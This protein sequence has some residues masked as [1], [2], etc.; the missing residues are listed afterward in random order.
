MKLRAGEHGAVSLR[1]GERLQVSDLVGG[2]CCQLVAVNTG[3]PRERFSAPNTMLLNKQVYYAEGATL[4]SYLCNPMLTIVETSTGH[5]AL[6]GPSSEGG[7]PPDD[8][9]VEACK[10]IGLARHQVPYPFLVFAHHV[11]GDDGSIGP[12]RS[13]SGKGDHVVLRADLDVTVALANT[14]R[15]VAGPDD[16]AVSVDVLPAE[17]EAAR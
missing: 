9:V 15:L 17:E 10:E 3:D 6:P 4:H 8:T 11:I 13:T 16:G 5:D 14:P 2:Q 7:D 1:Y 12:A